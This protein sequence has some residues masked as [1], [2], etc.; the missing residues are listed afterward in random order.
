MGGGRPR[1]IGSSTAPTRAK[2]RSE[3]LHFAPKHRKKRRLPIRAIAFVVILLVIL[4]G[5]AVVKASVAADPKLSVQVVMPARVLLAGTAP[6]PAW[7]AVG[8]AAVEV[9][10]LP[11]LGSSGGSTPVPLASLAKVMTAYVLLKDHPLAVGQ[12]GFTVTITAAQEADYHQRL[13]QA[14]SV[15][16]VTAGEQITELQLMQGLLVPSGN[17]VAELLADFD[18][19]SDSAF[20]ARMNATAAALGMDHTHYT[21]PAGLDSTTVSTAS[22]QLVLAAKAMANPVF[23]QIVAMPSVILPVA[24]LVTNFNSAVGKNGYVGIKTGSDSSSGGCLMFANQR[25]IAGHTVTI[26]GVVLGQDPGGTHTQSLIDAAV[27][28]SD[29]LIASVAAGISTRTVVPA[30]RVVARIANRE[31]RT[32]DVVTSSALTQLGYGG[33]SIGVSVRM[34]PVGTSL[35][36]GQAVGHV[37]APGVGPTTP[38]VASAA[39]PTVSLG[40]KLLHEY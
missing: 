17:N 15:V 21:D 28:A 27:A 26:L 8:E 10:G 31:G 37:G 30:G 13:A 1:G 2:K 32:V 3:H 4:L 23:A 36:A 19:G 40:W 35:R 22:D 39:L 33:E 7:P 16:P 14:E 5:A 29:Q 12:P 20:V 9:E 11:P 38:L 18:A 34:D 25:A 6:H 24:G